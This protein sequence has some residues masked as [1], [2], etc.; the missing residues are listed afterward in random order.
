MNVNHKR[1]SLNI[2]TII[3]IWVYP[4][5]LKKDILYNILSWYVWNRICAKCI[6]TLHNLKKRIHIYGKATNSI[7]ISIR[8][9]FVANCRLRRIF[10]YGFYVRHERLPQLRC[11]KS[12]EMETEKKLEYLFAFTS[13]KELKFTFFVSFERWR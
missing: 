2:I 9:V 6:N 4:I 10:P 7:Y 5:I 1:N 12:D 13:V 3:F 8:A 11:G